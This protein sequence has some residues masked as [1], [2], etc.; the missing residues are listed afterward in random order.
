MTEISSCFTSGNS[1]HNWQLAE[2]AGKLRKSHKFNKRGGKGQKREAKGLNN[3]NKGLRL[4]KNI[5]RNKNGSKYML[6][7]ELMFIA[8]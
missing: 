7:R 2:N 5:E 8:R 1:C 4:E 3:L 6:R